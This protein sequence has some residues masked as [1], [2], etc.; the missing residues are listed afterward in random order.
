[1]GGEQSVHFCWHAASFHK[2]VMIYS[3]CP[4]L[5]KTWAELQVQYYWEEVLDLLC[6][7]SGYLITKIYCK[8]LQHF[9]KVLCTTAFIHRDT[10]LGKQEI[11]SLKMGILKV[12]CNAES[13][14]ILSYAHSTLQLCVKHFIFIFGFWECGTPAISFQEIVSV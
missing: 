14:F 4:Y 3:S 6:F 10:F 9:L 1:M 7:V 13:L 8:Y 11:W 5:C 2:N 12:L